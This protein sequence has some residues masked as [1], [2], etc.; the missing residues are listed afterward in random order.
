MSALAYEECECAM[1]SEREGLLTE[2]FRLFGFGL[3]QDV[4]L[5]GLGREVV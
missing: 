4:R 3:V 2:G 1:G 5:S